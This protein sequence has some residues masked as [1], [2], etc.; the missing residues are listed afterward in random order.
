MSQ[1]P[2]ET[3]CNIAQWDPTA[4]KYFSEHTLAGELQEQWEVMIDSDSLPR[5]PPELLSGKWRSTVWIIRFYF[6]IMLLGIL[7][8]LV[9]SIA[10]WKWCFSLQISP[11]W[12]NWRMMP[13]GLLPEENLYPNC[14]PRRCWE[15]TDIILE[16]LERLWLH[17]KPWLGFGWCHWG[18]FE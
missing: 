2:M 18:V 11:L 5:C 15:D 7:L 17:Q 6:L 10:I 9:I 16:R 3:H 8:L 4:F 14:H 12:S 1:L 13:L